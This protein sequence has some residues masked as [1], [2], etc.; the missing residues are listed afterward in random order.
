MV[1]SNS[2]YGARAVLN[3][4]LG[5][6]RSS[7]IMGELQHALRLPEFRFS[8]FPAPRLWNKFF[9]WRNVSKVE[10][11]SWRAKH[12]FIPIGDAFLYLSPTERLTTPLEVSNTLLVPGY[13]RVA[14]INER[15]ERHRRLIEFAR[16]KGFDN[17]RVSLHRGEHHDL[18]VKRFY[19][20]HGVEVKNPTYF[21]SDSFL[22]SER[23]TILGSRYIVGD[24]V[25]ATCVRASFLKREIAIS[26]L[27][28]PV[29]EDP[30]LLADWA[31]EGYSSEVAAC[32]LGLTHLRERD[33][34]RDLLTDGLPDTV[35]KGLNLV[36]QAKQKGIPRYK[37]KAPNSLHQCPYC[38][39]T[40]VLYRSSKGLQCSSCRY[41]LLP[42]DWVFD[43]ESRQWERVEDRNI[44]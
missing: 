28:K 38:C 9:T 40:S 37:G 43:I 15:L 41:H 1:P 12:R 23:E 24:Y 42:T 32:L 30:P 26:P 21:T 7:P 8:S 5:R 3:Y 44:S 13:S 2:L 18:E 31:R 22:E 34:L 35:L 17:L 6:S 29:P 14:T 16:G 39:K 10:R 36:K 11:N 4:F 20:N 19:E 33:E 27:A 25:S